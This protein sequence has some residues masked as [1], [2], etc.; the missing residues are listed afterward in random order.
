MID[1]ALIDMFCASPV[2]VS[3]QNV[4]PGV[5]TL[6][7]VPALSDHMDLMD[8]MQSIKIDYEPVSPL[9]AIARAPAAGTPS[10]K[11]V[12]AAP[13]S[14]VSGLFDVR[15][16]VT[17]FNLSCDLEGLRPLARQHRHHQQRHE[18]HGDHG[19]DV[20]HRHDASHHAG[21]QVRGSTP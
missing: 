5:H 8:N 3:M 15:V 18:R 17:S 7:V 14:T 4:K 21:V 20:L 12:S 1:N 9:P 16:Q 6:S 10:I 13:G 19:P 2:T 11:I